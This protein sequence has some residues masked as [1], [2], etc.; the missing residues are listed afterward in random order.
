MD[1]D[2]RDG[3][4]RRASHVLQPDGARARSSH[5]HTGDEHGQVR[6]RSSRRN[7][8]DDFPGHDRLL[9]NIL[10]VDEGRRSRDGHC[11]LDAADAQFGVDRGGEGCRQLDTFAP[12]LRETRQRKRHG[13]GAG[14]EID[15]AVLTLFVGECGSNLFDQGW[16][17]GL[18]GDAGQDS[19]ARVPYR[20]RKGAGTLSSA[21][22]RKQE[23]GENDEV[24][25]R[26]PHSHGDSHHSGH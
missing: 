14:P 3:I 1:V 26:S 19:A 9:R 13:V 24:R 18:N 8:V 12:A 7:R 15:D 20:A 4:S 10:Y 17:A 25:I 11:L 22:V 23:H 5:R 2:P 6:K 21:S 16:A